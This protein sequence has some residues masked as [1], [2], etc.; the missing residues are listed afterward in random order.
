MC[1]WHRVWEKC[2][3]SKCRWMMNK[4]GGRNWMV[5]TIFGSITKSGFLKVDCRKS[6]FTVRSANRYTHTHTTH[7]IGNCLR[8][9]NRTS[10]W[11]KFIDIQI[12]I[13][14]D[15]QNKKWNQFNRSIQRMDDDGIGLALD[16]FMLWNISRL[17]NFFVWL[18]QFLINRIQRTPMKRLCF[19]SAHPNHHLS[20]SL[21]LPLISIL[22][23]STIAYLQ[24]ENFVLHIFLLSHNAH[25]TT[26]AVHF[27]CCA[28]VKRVFCF[29]LFSFLFF[30]FSFFLNCK[31]TIECQ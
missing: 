24:R 5:T 29:C 9:T 18:T 27:I 11:N 12:G 23:Y 26:S 31:Q 16:G 17:H 8:L 7:I 13:N 2:M 22:I 19:F 14:Y 21:S 6:K 25:L 20:L 1:M 4:I 28:N 10:C 15:G 3:Q 30:F